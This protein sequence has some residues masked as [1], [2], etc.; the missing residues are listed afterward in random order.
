MTL[1]R[2]TKVLL[3]LSAIAC[4]SGGG[5]GG[6]GGPGSGNC[7]NLAGSYVGTYACSDGS[8][9]PSEVVATQSGCTLT[10]TDKLDGVSQQYTVSGNTASRPITEDGLSGNCSVTVSGNSASLS[11][12]LSGDGQ[13]VSCSGTLSYQP[14]SG[15]G[16]GGGVGTGG[17]GGT[18]GGATCSQFWSEEPICD[19]CMSASCCTQMEQCAAGTPCDAFAFCINSY[20]PEFDPACVQTYCAAE[21]AAGGTALEALG[22]CY[23]NVCGTC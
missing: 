11:C 23:T 4:S 20:C 9:H 17:S 3:V 6:G 1:F 12:N 13:Q 19:A 18:G 2:V 15:G 16:T 8:T 10:T 21:Q 14:A 5:G 22:S 7:A